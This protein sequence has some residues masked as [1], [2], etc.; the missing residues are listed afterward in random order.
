MRAQL[1][2]RRRRWLGAV[3]IGVSLSLLGWLLGRAGLAAIG[4]VLRQADGRW[5]AGGLALGVLSTTVQ[6]T[7]WHALLAAVGLPRRWRRCLRLVYVG[8][9]FNTVLPSAVG[10]DVVRAVVVAEQPFERVPAA[11]SVVLQR[12]YNFP[13]MIAVL[14]LGLV[15]T[16]GDPAAARTRPAAAVAAAVGLAIVVVAAGPL[17][18]RLAGHSGW[19]RGRLTRAVAAML[20]TLDEVRLRRR[21]V[22]FASLRGASFWG[23]Q[24]LSQLCFMRA[25]GISPGLGYAAV[26]VTTVNLATLLPISINGYGVR[27]SGYTAFLVAPHLATVAQAL[28]ASFLLA[29]QTLLWGMAGVGCWMAPHVRGRAMARLDYGGPSAPPP[30]NCVDKSTWEAMRT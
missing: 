20:R 30:V 21:I 26:V 17:P 25:V 18:G 16:L 1:P 28:G 10:G 5:V 24:A 14:V 13:G 22:A 3:R 29:A 11:A 2:R 23:L 12:L 19:Q 7:Q 9:A 8:Y 27:E 4:H 15:L 6:A